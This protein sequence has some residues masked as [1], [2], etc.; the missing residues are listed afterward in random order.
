MAL[1]AANKGGGNFPAH[2]ILRRIMTQRA[3]RYTD[4]GPNLTPL[5]SAQFRLEGTRLQVANARLT[6]DAINE[7]IGRVI[8]Y[9]RLRGIST[10]WAVTHNSTGEEALPQALL[11]HGFVL[12]E[13]L[14]LMARQGDLDVRVNPAVSI[15]PITTWSLMWAYERGSR[16]S[17]YD[18]PNPDDALVT[19]RAH[20]R[21]RQQEMGWYRYYIATLENQFAGGMYVSQWEDVPTL[22]GVYTLDAARRRGVATAA[23]VHAI[24]DVVKAGQDAYCLY[25]K[26]GNPA[27][28]LY[29]ELG[30]Q[31]L[32]VE[33]TYILES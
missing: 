30:F 11:A 18:D 8:S 26:E 24:H 25:V 1:T 12:D 10:I 33:E 5:G 3:L 22:M 15:T 23:L 4:Q 31:T 6:P 16:R 28:H 19:A 29:H 14:I 21:W 2:D 27:R 13:R 32:G 7:A 17:F 20:E 9:S